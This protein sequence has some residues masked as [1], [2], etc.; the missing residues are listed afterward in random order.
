MRFFKKPCPLLAKAGAAVL[1]GWLLLASATNAVAQ[2]DTFSLNNMMGEDRLFDI[3]G[4]TQIGYHNDSTGLF[5]QHPDR[6]NLHQ[7][8]LYTE[9]VADGSDGLDFGFRFDTVYGVDAQEVQ[10]FGNSPGRY[11]EDWDHG[12]YG[13]ALPQLYGEVAYGDFSAIFGHFYTIVGFELATAP[14]NFFYSHDFTMFNNEPFTHTGVLTTY[15]VNDRLTL[16]NGWTAGWDTGF[17][18]DNDAVASRLT[19]DGLPAL[20]LAGNPIEDDPSDGS[21]GSNYVGGIS[22]DLTD[23]TNVT[24][25]ITTGDFGQR[26]EGFEHTFVLQ[27]QATDDLSFV[28]ENDFLYANNVAGPGRVDSYDFTQYAFYTINDNFSVGARGEVWVYDDHSISEFTTGVNIRPWGSPDDAPVNFVLRPELRWQWA[29]DEKDR[30]FFN[31]AFGIPAEND[32][33]TLFGIDAILVY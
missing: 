10:A 6:L 25:A 15:D 27:W 8:Y 33:K 30:R 7:Q 31:N 1:G 13:W 14:D 4:W 28:F 17:D 11:D 3:G 26:G 21:K 20:D 18:R 24:Y 23:T 29:E 16:Y 22:Y 5:N 9:R 12:I 2:D 32:G 19:P